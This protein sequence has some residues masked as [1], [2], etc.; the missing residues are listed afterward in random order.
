MTE[1]ERSIRDFINRYQR[2]HVSK[3]TI[4]AYR[5]DLYDFFEFVSRSC[6]EALSGDIKKKV[7]LDYLDHLKALYAPSTVH[8]KGTVVYLF[9]KDQ[10]E[11]RE[12][13]VLP[14]RNMKE[15]D[16]YLPVKEVNS[17]RALT[18]EEIEQVFETVDS[19]PFQSAFMRFLYDTGCRVSEALSA[20][21]EDVK[22]HSSGS[23]T[24]QV[25]GKGKGGMSK[26]RVVVI[27]KE[28][29]RC[30]EIR[31]LT[32]R[33]DSD[34]IFVSD[35]HGEPYNPR[36]IN[37]MLAK[38]SNIIGI[39]S[40]SSHMFRKT[41]ATRLISNGMSIEYVAEYLG[42]ESIET[43]KKYYLDL[44]QNVA[45]KFMTHIENN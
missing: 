39:E 18:K 5:S 45:D 1:L 14:F 25:Y 4:D 32:Q 26:K 36:T 35:K 24:I 31:K 6:P 17:V 3:N 37:N 10:F 27:K 43:T 40:I 41:I 7:Y 30:M 29:M 13:D 44:Q 28:T 8:R 19:D 42:H 22:P 2:R 33:W 15:L 9:S 38:I 12:S 20:K 23:Y 16:M 21:W 11:N 34:Y